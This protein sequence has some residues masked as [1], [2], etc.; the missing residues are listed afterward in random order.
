MAQWLRICLSTQRHGFNPRSGTISHATGQLRLHAL[1]TEPALWSPRAAAAEPV[2]TGRKPADPEAAHPDRR[3]RGENSSTA[4]KTPLAATR[5]GPSREQSRPS[6][7]TH[8]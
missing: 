7:G 2:S 8:K 5:E 3:P 4:V 6:A 1:A